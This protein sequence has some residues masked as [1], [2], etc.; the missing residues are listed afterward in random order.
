MARIFD[1][2]RRSYFPDQK[3]ISINEAFCSHFKLREMPDE[4]N[5]SHELVVVGSA[6]DPATERIVGYLAAE[7][8][9]RINAV[10][11]RVFKDGDREY[12]TRVWLREPTYADVVAEDSPIAK[13]WNG[14]C[15]TRRRC[16]C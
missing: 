8:G 15:G 12:L 3:S 7:Y 16:A 11:F 5:D 6:F 13:E 14:E 10:F 4:I 2:Y 1:G 9:V